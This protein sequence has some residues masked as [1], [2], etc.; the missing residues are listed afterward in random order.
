MWYSDRYFS[1]DRQFEMHKKAKTKDMV[2]GKCK[3]CCAYFTIVV[4][5]LVMYVVYAHW[6]CLLEA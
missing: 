3:L 2:L 4:L 6:N 5:M 1:T